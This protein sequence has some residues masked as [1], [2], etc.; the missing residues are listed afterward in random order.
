MLIYSDRY[1]GWGKQ[2]PQQWGPAS[3]VQRAIIQNANQLG[4]PEIGSFIPFWEQGGRRVRDHGAIPITWD[5]RH[6]N[7]AWPSWVSNGVYL[8]NHLD[9]STPPIKLLESAAFFADAITSITVGCRVTFDLNDGGPLGIWGI[10]GTTNG[11]SLKF[12]T[13]PQQFDVTVNANS[14]TDYEALS[15]TTFTPEGQQLDLVVVLDNNNIYLYIN[16]VLDGSG[17][18]TGNI[19]ANTDLP[20][21]GNA[22]IQELANDRWGGTISS[23]WATRNALTPDQIAFMYDAPFALL[24]PVPE[25]SVFD[26]GATEPTPTTSPLIYTS[27]NRGWGKQKPKQWGPIAS[28]QLALFKNAERMGIDPQSIA[29]AMPLWNAGNQIDYSKNRLIGTNV[30]TTF[31]RDHLHFNGTNA[32]IE[33]DQ[34]VIDLSEPWSFLGEVTPFDMDTG[35]WETFFGFGKFPRASS[36]EFVVIG[37]DET[38]TDLK[39]STSSESP[40]TGSTVIEDVRQSYCL[41]YDG[42]DLIAYVDGVEDYSVT[43]TG[44]GWQTSNRILTAR[45]TDSDANHGYTEMDMFSLLLIQPMLSDEQ[46]ARIADAPFELW[47]PVPETYFFDS[48][49]TTGSDVTL[50]AVVGGEFDLGSTAT[51][52]QPNLVYALVGAETESGYIPV[53]TQ[54]VT[55]NLQ[56]VV[57]AEADAGQTATYSQP[58]SLT[59]VVGGE[60]DTGY[61]PILSQTASGIYQAVTGTETDAGHTP[62][63]V[64]PNSL[65][66]AVGAE[67]ESGYTATISQSIV[68]NLQAIAGSESESGYTATYT[69]PNLLTALFGNEYDAGYV[70]TLTQS[71]DVSLQAVSGS[72]LDMGYIASYSSSTVCVVSLTEVDIQRIAE[73]VWRYQR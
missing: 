10:G 5:L 71:E 6:I 57:G 31:D 18:Y 46:I 28:V 22:F 32:E 72:E 70:P 43:P 41:A 61:I 33:F 12:K 29:L 9:N 16:G 40:G 3:A 21:I 30:S 47:Q 38:S 68:T 65:I 59:A 1:R 51:L 48:G 73:A 69:Q 27:S 4:L 23:Y 45:N 44:S 37:A 58:N 49:T 62:V 54:S 26:F 19:A 14:S 17:T 56:A 39:I 11:L 67:S 13:T 53:L 34:K 42:T 66:A 15:T 25:I 52:S 55:T 50:Q 35:E 8:D 36:T 2:K 63:L 64:H 24:H 20:G 60:V 7:L